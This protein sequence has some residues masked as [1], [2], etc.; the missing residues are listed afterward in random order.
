M[1]C[2]KE[3]DPEDQSN[4]PHPEFDLGRSQVILH[5]SVALKI[6]LLSSKTSKATVVYF[7]GLLRLTKFSPV[8]LLCYLKLTF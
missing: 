8:E 4:V 7:L 5:F 6:S 2:H 1:C 3:P